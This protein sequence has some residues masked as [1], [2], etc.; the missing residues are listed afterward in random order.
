MIY[1][2]TQI[3]N[4]FECG[5]I[6]TQGS[7]ILSP[8]SVGGEKTQEFSKMRT[9]EGAFLTNPSPILNKV[10]NLI[11]SLTQLP[12]ENQEPPHLIKYEIGG[13]YKPHYDYYEDNWEL[14]KKELQRGGNRKFSCL[15]YLNDNFK[16]GETYFPYNKIT[17]TPSIGNLV[18]WSNLSNG[19]PNLNSYHAGLPI[20]EGTKWALIVW[21]REN[22]Y[23]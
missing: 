12:I 9:G 7:P 19:K 16:G 17:I 13:E 23:L 22:K 14:H 11:S 15:F 6:I 8:L 21:V 10:K 20:T 4:S 5:E 3:L 1:P 18:I 2:Y